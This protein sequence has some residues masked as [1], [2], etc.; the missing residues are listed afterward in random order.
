[1][2]DKTRL[3]RL[4]ERAVT[5]RAQIDKILDEGLL[6]HVGYVIDGRPVVIPTF[7]ARDGD[8]VLVHGSNTAGM[9]KA[10]RRGSP[11][12]ITV[13][14]LDG[15][16]VAR[17]GFNSSANYRTVVIHGYGTILG[18]ED[19][20]RALDVIVEALIPGRSADIRPNTA[21]ESKQTTVFAVDLDEVS[22]KV[23]TGGPHD[24]PE[25]LGSASW[26]G[27]VPIRVTAGQPEPSEDLADGIPIPEYLLPYRR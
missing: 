5:D 19:Q 13:T 16:V 21:V 6:C 8:R 18:D 7:Y 4:P 27:V 3:G 11:L 15:I 10:V 23:R 26:A 17:S 14:H 20:E 2:S 9:I 22:A 12:C 25:D 1:L 24:D